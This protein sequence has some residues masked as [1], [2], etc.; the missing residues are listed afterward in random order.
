[1]AETEGIRVLCSVLG[2]G[3][4]SEVEYF[5]PPKDTMR[6]DFATFALKEFLEQGTMAVKINSVMQEQSQSCEEFG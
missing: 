3:E 1:M 5:F 4:Y 2:A 6:T